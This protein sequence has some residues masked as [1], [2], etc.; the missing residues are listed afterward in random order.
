M[1][2]ERH[3]KAKILTPQEIYLLFNQGLKTQRDRTLFGFCLYTACRIN[4]ASPNSTPTW[5]SNQIK[6]KERSQV[7]RVCHTSGKEHFGS[8]LKLSPTISLAFHPIRVLL[9]EDKSL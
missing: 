7:E 9:R 3:G 4:E 5:K 8:S 6:S 1:K 2:R